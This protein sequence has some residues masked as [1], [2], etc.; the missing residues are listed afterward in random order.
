MEC[1]YSW[2]LLGQPQKKFISTSVLYTRDV[3]LYQCD[4]KCYSGITHPSSVIA[5]RV[6]PGRACM[7]MNYIQWACIDISHSVDP[8]RIEALVCNE[9]LYMYYNY[10][11]YSVKIVGIPASLCTGTLSGGSRPGPVNK[12]KEVSS[13][14]I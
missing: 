4:V 10:N 3:G 9:G 1:E 8:V 12:K 5:V 6:E 14:G 11:V 2:Q 13:S 7:H